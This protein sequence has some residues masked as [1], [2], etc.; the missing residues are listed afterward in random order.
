MRQ[1]DKY[2][3]A[4]LGWFPPILTAARKRNLGESVVRL[5]RAQERL[6]DGRL[7]VVVCGEFK[8]GKSS[9]LNALL[10]EP[11]PYLF[12]T[13]TMFATNVVSTVT[14]GATEHITVML[15]S[16]GGVEQRRI[17]RAELVS[18]VTESGNPHNAKK[19]LAIVIKTPNPRLESG[20]TL[21]DTPGVGGVYAAHTAVT[22]GFLPSADAIVFVADATQPLTESELDF[23]RQTVT[24]TKVTDD[25]DGLLPVLT[26]IDM[27]DYGPILANTR[28]KIAEVTGWPEASVTVTPVSAQAKIDYLLQD[29]VEDLELSNFPAL[30]E[31]I[32]GALSRRRTTVLL[33]GALSELDA[34]VQALLEP[35]L[36]EQQALKEETPGK[37]A[38]M[39]AEAAA[40]EV[41]FARL[42]LADEG[43]RAELSRQLTDCRRELVRTAKAQIE[44]IWD[45]VNGEYLYQYKY[46]EDPR[47]LVKQVTSRAVLVMG[48]TSELAARRVAWIQRDLADRSGLA[49]TQR[50]FDDLPPPA[51]PYL[52]PTGRLESTP[53]DAAMRK[54]QDSLSLA[55]VGATIGALIGTVIVPGITTAIFSS[56]GAL[57]GAGLGYLT[58]AGATRRE[59]I[60]ARR[61]SLKTELTPLKRSQLLHIEEAVDALIADFTSAVT[62]ELRSRITEARQSARDQA[63]RLMRASRQTGQDAERRLVELDREVAPLTRMHADIAAVV[64]EITHHGPPA[65]HAHASDHKAGE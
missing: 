63:E 3:A 50:R 41:E 32:W 62:A 16:E 56:L 5:A 51:V 54:T 36:S 30:E 21:V 14:Y 23:L 24:S 65:I 38:Q 29:D 43:W 60:A 59:E 13:D 7:T 10:E 22:L 37:V 8:R 25:E 34:S 48:E 58:A 19:A 27:V 15:E 49:V 39:Q 31:R 64:A 33:G 20:L 45:D 9:L 57:V 46:L 17:G 2:R 12:P 47:K 4:V 18:Y 61:Q 44:Q 53:D 26:K 40:R 1:F 28:T 55:G 35:L 6:R 42:S 11:E 52:D